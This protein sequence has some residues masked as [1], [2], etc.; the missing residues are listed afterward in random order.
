MRR[1]GR[2]PRATHFL[3]TAQAPL[4]VWHNWIAPAATP[5]PML[6]LSDTVAPLA[7]VPDIPAQTR[8]A[9]EERATTSTTL[10]L[11]AASPQ[12]RGTRS[13]PRTSPRH[14]PLTARLSTTTRSNASTSQVRGCRACFAAGLLARGALNSGCLEVQHGS[15]K[16]F[17]TEVDF[18][19]VLSCC[20]MAAAHATHRRVLL[21]LLLSGMTQGRGV[22]RL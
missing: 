6:S 21:L 17:A 11:R 1:C 2:T 12:P 19:C 4:R 5:A 16:I 9:R 7:A 14:S 15:S 10:R 22:S 13:P 3:V 8:A 18:E 20:S